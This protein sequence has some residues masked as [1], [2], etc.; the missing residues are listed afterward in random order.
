MR[1]RRMTLLGLLIASALL[2][3]CGGGGGSNEPSLGTVFVRNDS[4]QGMSPLTATALFFRPEGSIDPGPNL[5][6]QDVAPGQ[7]V[8]VGL[9]EPGKYI[10]QLLLSNGGS[11]IEEHVVA[12]GAPTNVVVPIL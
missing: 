5:L 6:V 12:A 1:P 10:A 3:G 8:A 11:I 7:V 2:A 4:N 9:F